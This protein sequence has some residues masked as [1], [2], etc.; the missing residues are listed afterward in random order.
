MNPPISD[1]DSSSLLAIL[2]D[3]DDPDALEIFGADDAAREDRGTKKSTENP[4]GKSQSSKKKKKAPS[5]ED[6]LSTVADAIEPFQVDERQSRGPV[7]HHQQPISARRPSH[8]R[9]R[10]LSRLRSLSRRRESVDSERRRAEEAHKLADVVR[11]EV[12]GLMREVAA[13]DKVLDRWYTSSGS[14]SAG[15]SSRSTAPEDFW[16]QPGSSGGRRFSNS[17]PGTSPDRSERYYPDRPTSHLR[18]RDS[19][20]HADERKHWTDPVFKPQ[21]TYRE[22]SRGPRYLRDRRQVYDDYP[23]AR[24]RRHS[25]ER[26]YSS[27]HIQRRVTDYPESFRVADFG[28]PSGRGVDYERARMNDREDRRR[29]AH[30][31]RHGRRKAFSY[32]DSYEDPV[33]MHSEIPASTSQT[34]GDHSAGEQQNAPDV[35]TSPKTTVLAE[36]IVPSH[37]DFDQHDLDHA[38]S[39]SSP[40]LVVSPMIDSKAEEEVV[41]HGGVEDC[42]ADYAQSVFSQASIAPSMTS[43]G[44]TAAATGT[45]EMIDCIISTMFCTDGLQR[46]DFAALKEPGIVSE[47]Y[48]RNICRMIQTFGMEL[49][50]EATSPIQSRTAVAMQ[51][52]SVSTHVAREMM[53]RVVGPQ[54]KPDHVTYACELTND[55]QQ[56]DASIES[57]DEDDDASNE[58]PEHEAEIRS[59]ILD[60]HACLRFK[61]SLVEF[62][63]KPYEGRI[64]SAL[65]SDL[66]RDLHQDKVSLMRTARELSWVP[67]NLFSFSHDRSLAAADLIKGL[68]EDSM[69]ESW[70]WSPLEKRKHRLQANLC[71]LS[72][73]CVSLS[74]HR[75]P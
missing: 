63:H 25:R 35:L 26:E 66:P 36:G 28:P 10:S 5:Y 64:M 57:A 20:G 3:A 11:N 30:E 8:S 68:I 56:S 38:G 65:S 33:A 59:F 9:Q 2:H 70:D 75:L 49:R 48:R 39:I 58:G 37:E 72:W 19:S 60:S 69:G 47:R 14:G 52:R 40:D 18:R 13:E 17:T 51:T 46:F 6:Y 34:E 71:R 32:W 24:Q 74:E 54:S 15:S 55:D 4:N 67:T 31:E 50:T 29:Y 12:R 43:L 45:T 23:S 73:R 22:H 53:I 16:S 7:A 44:G 1:Y 42:N 61:N 41:S 62:V 21:D 27:P